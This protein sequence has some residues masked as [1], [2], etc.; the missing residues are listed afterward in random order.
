MKYLRYLLLAALLAFCF[1][2]MTEAA[3]TTFTQTVSVSDFSSVSLAKGQAIYHR[4]SVRGCFPLDAQPGSPSVPVKLV[5]IL[6]PFNAAVTGL[7]ITGSSAKILPGSFNPF[8][9]QSPVP[10]NGQ[11][12]PE[13]V[14]SDPAFY[15]LKG[16]FPGRLARIKQ[17]TAR[18]E[19]KVVVVEVFPL[20]YDPSKT[21]LTLYT[22]IS[23]EIEYV[24]NN[25]EE[26]PVKRRSATAQNMMDGSLASAID[27]KSDIARLSLSARLIEKG[28]PAE[29]PAA[30]LPSINGCPVDY[31][32]ITSETLAPQ[33]QRLADWKTEKGI[34]TM[35][36]ST[37]W[38]ESHYQGAD[39]QEKIR[40]FVQDAWANWGTVL[41]LLGGDTSVIPARYVPW[42]IWPQYIPDLRIPADI[43]YSDIADTSCSG[44]IR[45][46]NFDSNHDGK[47]GD[48]LGGDVVDLQ[49]D[50]FLGRAPV[51]TLT[52]AQT[53]VDKVLAYEK[54]P[55]AG[56]GSSFLML[57]DGGFAWSPEAI[58]NCPLSSD[59]PWIDTY[60]LYRPAVDSVNFQWAGDQ[61]LDADAAR[62]ELN[63][64]YNMV[65]HIDHGGNYQLSTASAG[66]GGWL[67][68]ADA[69]RLANINRPSVFI[70]PACSPNAFDY[71]CFSRHLLNNPGGGA[72]A[73]IGNSRIGWV[74]QSYMCQMFFNGLYQFHQRMLGS[75]FT[76]M[77]G[78][79][80]PYSLFSMNL[81]GDP[82]M[83]LWSD[84]PKTL[85][86]DLPDQFTLGDS[87]LKVEISGPASGEQVQ[88]AVFK[89]N[90][91]FQVVSAAIP[92]SVT[93]PVSPLTEGRLLVTV[94]GANFKP[95]QTA[96]QVVAPGP[97]HPFIGSYT[98]RDDGRISDDK[99]NGNSDRILNPGETV[100]LYPALTNNGQS[101]LR[102]ARV[103]L[104]SA[105]PLVKITDSI[106]SLP[107]LEPGQTLVC[108]SLLGPSFTLAVSPLIRSDRPLQLNAVFSD[109][110]GL[111]SSNL[112]P[113]R[114]NLS[115]EINTDILSDSLVVTSYVLSSAIGQ[116][117]G[118]KYLFVVLD[119]VVI[120][121]FGSGQARN[122][123]MTISPASGNI[124]GSLSRVLRFG[125]IPAGGFSV[126]QSMTSMP[127]RTEVGDPLNLLLTVRD[128]YGREH[129]QMIRRLEVPNP[130]CNLQT[131]SLSSGRIQINWSLTGSGIG[132]RGFNLYR[133]TFAQLSFT[134]VNPALVEGSRTYTDEGLPANTVY[135]Y[136]VSA[137]DS[138]SGE[139]PL[140]PCPDTIKT[141]PALMPGFPAAMGNGAWGSRMWSS[142]AAGDINKDGFEEIVMG[143]D[144]GKVYAFDHLGNFLSGW[145]VEIG[146]TIDQ[147]SPAL[148]DLDGDGLLEI[149]MGSGGWYTVPGDGKVHVLRH[150]GSEQFGWPQAVCGDAFA[151]TAVADLNDDGRYE[152][153]AATTGGN[154]Y[155]WEAGGSLV[156]GWPVFAGGPVWAAPAVGNLDG[157]PRPEIVV[158]ANCGGALKLLV[159]KNDGTDLPGWPI[160]VQSSAGFA[161]SSPV[162]AD[163]DDDGA[164]EIVLGAETYSSSASTKSYCFKTNGS[165][166]P[167]WP[168]GFACG[169]R[170][171]CSPAIADLDGD[172]MLDA[173]FVAS[174][175]LL[176]AYSNQGVNRM[177][178]EVQTGSNG[179]TNPIAADIDSD[180]I[181][182]LLLTT[183]SGYLY[184]FEGA[185]GSLTPGYPIWIEPS[186]SAPALSDINRDGKME[187]LAF[188]WGSHK[189]F[190]WELG[191]S[192]AKSAGSG[193]STFRGNMRRTGCH[194]DALTANL[195]G[196]QQA[197]LAPTS[198]I[199][200]RLGQNYPNPV[201][202]QTAISYQITRPGKVKI[203]V[204]NLTGQLVKT[205]VNEDRD[206][207]SY[208]IKW[209]GKNEQDHGVSSGTYIYR[210][211][212]PGFNAA[213]KMLVLK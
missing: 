107:L 102:N 14:D 199:V 193:G 108:D 82:S 154:I 188:G 205:L 178:W 7:T 170:I 206:P 76:Y 121:N 25:G 23:F 49:S 53:F 187:L 167:G 147:S 97:A 100:A 179:R 67:Y 130:V 33:F 185:D 156:P 157:D 74:Y 101:S 21:Q 64:G 213:K 11:A 125:D 35:V 190:A 78:F 123:M 54:D 41:V 57:A 99:S 192:S 51:N 24:L 173:A 86:V 209:N 168:V 55:P 26:P 70:T 90:E 52:Q 62:S 63:K 22:S 166:L 158:T 129:R 165:Q 5:N 103:I 42:V 50:L 150:D 45:N 88:V 32:I 79:R 105:D 172:G 34:Y 89:Q 28:G 113:A 115:Q 160:I 155:A 171:V 9:A 202:G 30:E 72:A 59:A 161:L 13:F 36:K 109:D 189:L 118:D 139:S 39:L 181:T 140:F 135:I 137:V 122:V 164:N 163:M 1:S 48:V 10:L 31:L 37:R 77:Q 65:Y 40:R 141:Q 29:S 56:F 169:T 142:P 4:L 183:E 66:G 210:L 85:T 138:F 124:I 131:F 198:G 191:V 98:I 19:N 159:L 120:G 18:G 174:N 83:M 144:D 207:G 152:I 111:A 112:R 6:V 81:M 143:S 27:N 180:G 73:F 196:V 182:E 204:Y 175:G 145:P 211:E 201:K 200:S 197:A 126:G 16:D 12:A 95:R 148:A 203:N 177:L 3:G 133:K 94:T 17:V 71:D 2:Q 117:L 208:Q 134:K 38:I 69:D 44:D 136:T 75:S 58:N 116:N 110:I 96:C 93:L 80:D 128:A 114:M 149:V 68:R 91:V 104:R 84:E 132:I 186:W 194:A 162:L 15:D 184:A 92:S 20:Q 119:S 61:K 87:M 127:F 8:P 47:Y 176:R 195:R 106:I 212:S 153:V 60:E 146:G 151:A 46:Y 43:Y